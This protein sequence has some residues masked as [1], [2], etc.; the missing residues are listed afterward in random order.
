M[1]SSQD[2]YSVSEADLKG[3]K[4]SHSLHRVISAIDIISHEQIVGVRGLA[5]DSEQFAQVVELSMDIATNGDG[6]AYLLH[7]R[8]IY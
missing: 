8:L 2:G 4:K 1:V 6:C 3:D 5:A 7:V